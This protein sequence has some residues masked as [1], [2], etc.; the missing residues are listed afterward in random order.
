MNPELIAYLLTWAVFYTGYPAPDVQPVIEYVPHSYFVRKM[1]NFVDTPLK[2]CRIRAMY[3]DD[4]DRV[5]FLDERFKDQQIAHVKGIIVHE[6][7]HYLQDLT[8][9]WKNMRKWQRDIR[10]QEKAY[11]QREAYMVQDKYML[12]VH[13]VRLLFRRKYSPCGEF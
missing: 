4:V 1:C 9:D 2:P 6:M 8:G 12:D 7:V 11:R 3:N 5:I 10:C 13:G